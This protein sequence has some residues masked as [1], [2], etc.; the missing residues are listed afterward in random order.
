MLAA[1]L[2]PLTDPMSGFFAIRRT[3]WEQA[4]RLDPIG[5]K[6]ALELYVKGGCSRPAEVPIT[7]AARAAGVS[8]LSFR[9]QLQYLRHLGKLYRFRFPRV[10]VFA[11]VVLLIAGTFVILGVL[12]VLRSPL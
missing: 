5:Y 1:P 11:I 9:Q 7:F 12:R 3:T 2:V 10:S 8:K 4:A 6:I